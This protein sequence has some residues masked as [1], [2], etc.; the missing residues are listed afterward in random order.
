M[1]LFRQLQLD[2]LTRLIVAM[3]LAAIGTSLASHPRDTRQAQLP[4]VP[5]RALDP[6]SP[7]RTLWKQLNQ[8]TK[9]LSLVCMRW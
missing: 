8:N 4:S 7:N 5:L 1:F 3:Y 2:G 9:E 6:W